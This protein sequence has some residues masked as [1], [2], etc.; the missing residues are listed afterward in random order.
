MPGLPNARH[1]YAIAR[2]ELR[3]GWRKF[4]SKSVV[5]VLAFGLVALLGL[6]FTAAATYG[7]YLAGQALVENPG[8][9][10]ELVALVPAGLGAFVLFMAAYMTVIQIGDIDV[11]DGY[12]TTV[13]ARDVVGGL[14]LSGYVRVTGFV[15]VPLVVASAGFAVG[16][17]EPLAF[18]LTVLAVVALT[19]TA[20]LVGYPLGAAVGYLL[21]QSELVAR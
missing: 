12:L 10:A 9:A 4:R 2:N 1:S 3:V 13:P 15:T 14:L 20:F 16:A 5:Q 8:E 21:G 7:A 17:G 18:P 19:V 11:R 6:G